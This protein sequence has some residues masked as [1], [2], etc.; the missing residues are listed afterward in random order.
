MLIAIAEME[1]H[2]NPTHDH[3]IAVMGLPKSST[4]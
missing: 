4:L 3:W 1:N 2:R